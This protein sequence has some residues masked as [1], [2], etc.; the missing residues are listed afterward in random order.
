M[1]YGEKIAR[2]RK[3]NNMTQAELGEVLN[4]T[5]QAVSK[6]ERGESQP[7]FDTLSKISKLFKVPI[8]YFEDGAEE[9]VV[10][11][12]AAAT[13]SV[14]VAQPQEQAQAEMLGV[15]VQCGKVVREGEEETTQPK[16]IC[17]ACAELN[18]KEQEERIREAQRQEEIKIQRKQDRVNYRKS[19]M[20]KR[21]NLALI[22]GA[23]P[24]LAL[25][26]TFL[27][28]A[29][30]AEKQQFS[31]IFGVG[32]VF[33]LMA[34]TFTAQLIWGWGDCTVYEVLTGGGHILS[35]P[36]LIFEFSPEGLIWLIVMKIV[37]FFVAAIVF[38]GS[39]IFC[40]IGSILISP[41]MFIPSLL[42]YNRQIRKVN[43][44]NVDI[45]E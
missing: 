37:L 17:K 15:C 14:S 31:F 8:A 27:V 44:H 39:I 11:A 41:I 21:R 45:A 20:R 34:Y 38:V 25:L 18:R 10:E 43:E 32:C 19:S 30:R 7:D 24:A 6:W 35:L 2:L 23:I 13:A 4:V 28:L 22:I 26:I 16:L 1:T 42:W 3:K 36:G 5:Y 12:E 33:A 29:L 40:V 9:E